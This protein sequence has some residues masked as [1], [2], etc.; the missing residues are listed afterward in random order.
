V[1]PSKEP[2]INFLCNIWVRTDEFINKNDTE[3]FCN[4]VHHTPFVKRERPEVLERRAEKNLSHEIFILDKL[5]RL[6]GLVVTVPGYRFR[7]P[8]FDSRC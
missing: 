6:C 2:Q 1:A 8:E 3:C 4:P 5:D 7:G